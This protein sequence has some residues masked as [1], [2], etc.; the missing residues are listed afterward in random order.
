ML[1]L[2]LHTRRSASTA[3][4]WCGLVALLAPEALAASNSPPSNPEERPDKSGYTLFNPTP[5]ALMREMSADRPDKTDSPFTVDAG[6]FQV[7]MD[8]ANLTYDGRDS[9][10]TNGPLT[11]VE[12]APMNLK[13]GLLNNLDFQLLYTSYRWE[14]TEDPQTGTTQRASG[15]DGITPRL[16]LN[17]VG[18]DGGFFGV[19]K[20][21]SI[22]TAAKMAAATS[23][24]STIP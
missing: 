23:R 3:A 5:R 19:C 9:S 10:G 11:S 8:L 2:W 12:V 18:N 21:P 24:N 6:H 14:R 20:A 13:V 17:L 16:K 22:S 15:F 1:L 7:E 4:G